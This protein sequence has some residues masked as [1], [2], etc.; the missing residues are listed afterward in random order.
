MERPD[1]E[2]GKN[3]FLLSTVPTLD[4]TIPLVQAQHRIVRRIQ[5]KQAAEARIKTDPLRGQNA[6]NMRM[7]DQQHILPRF[8]KRHHLPDHVTGAGRGI[9]KAFT[10]TGM[11]LHTF[12]ARKRLLPIRIHEFRQ[13]R[14]PITPHIPIET[15]HITHRL[16][17]APLSTAIIPFRNIIK[18]GN[19]TETSQ[20]RRLL[21]PLQRAGEYAIIIETLRE[22]HPKPFSG[23]YCL[24]LT[25]CGQGN[26]RTPRMLAGFAPHGLPMTEHDQ[27]SSCCH[28]SIAI[29]SV[30]THSH[31]L[32][33]MPLPSYQRR[34]FQRV[35]RLFATSQCAHGS[36]L[37]Y[38][39]DETY[40]ATGSTTDRAVETLHR[41]DDKV[42][43]L[44]KQR[45]EDPDS[46]TDKLIKSVLPAI[47][48]MVAGKLFQVTW[49]RA[50]ARR[51]ASSGESSSNA[52]GLMM[53]IAFAAASAALGAVISTLSDRGSQALVDFRH[54]KHHR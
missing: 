20:T 36:R 46:A 44:R 25:Y 48:G 39:S 23:R 2:T 9:I 35:E 24:L 29:L 50:Q 32:P 47:T 38:M 4:N 5:T 27:T 19:L 8:D 54:R 52:K 11:H 18:R 34:V 17:G 43:M 7:R 6:Q 1:H 15:G 13:R 41:I 21:R 40:N 53:N 33:R 12:A 14:R 22:R 42:A 3:S 45:L 26:I 49:D 16:T 51:K 37:V 10:G 28:G 30:F 31:T